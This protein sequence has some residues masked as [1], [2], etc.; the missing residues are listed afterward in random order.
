VRLHALIAEHGPRTTLEVAWAEEIPT[1]L[2]VEMIGGAE[3]Q[4][5]VCRDEAPGLVIPGLDSDG[6]G[7][8]RWWRNIFQGYVW[9]GQE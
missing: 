2:A 7:E 5:D 6:G 1:A 8:V 4:G 9:D 3:A